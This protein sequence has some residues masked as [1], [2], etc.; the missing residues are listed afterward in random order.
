M[1]LWDPMR[2][3]ISICFGIF[4]VSGVPDSR[5]G[6]CPRLLATLWMAAL[7]SKNPRRRLDHPMEGWERLA[8]AISFVT[9]IACP[10]FGS[11]RALTLCHLDEVRSSYYAARSVQV[12]QMWMKIVHRAKREAY[13]RRYERIGANLMSASAHRRKSDEYWK[14]LERIFPGAYIQ[15]Q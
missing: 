13:W 11:M 4:M 1:P 8:L 9:S 12:M 14:L 6:V 5:A 10:I 3:T 15:F 2:S 7:L